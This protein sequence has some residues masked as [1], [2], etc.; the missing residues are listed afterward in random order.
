MWGLVHQH[1][2]FPYHGIQS[3]TLH[4]MEFATQKNGVFREVVINAKGC[5]G[6][7]CH[8]KAI[9]LHVLQ[10]REHGA[11]TKEMLY[12]YYEHGT[13]HHSNPFDITE[14]LRLTVCFIGPTISFIPKYV[15][16]RSI[17]VNGTM[18]LLN[19]RVYSDIFCLIRLWFSDAILCYLHFQNAPVVNFCLPHSTA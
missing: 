4:T 5:D 11:P 14:I 15:S 6:T 12:S 3:A 2:D 8:D 16:E 19:K 7:F 1:L 17:C 10:L 13:C 9:I 18:A